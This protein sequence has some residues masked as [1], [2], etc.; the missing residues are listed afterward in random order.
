MIDSNYVMRIRLTLTEKILGTAPSD[1]EIY[2]NFIGSKAEN[3][4]TV[5]EEVEVLGVDEV[6]EKGMTIFPKRLKDG[7]PFIYDYQMKGFFKEA[8][9]MLRRADKDPFSGRKS[10]KY[11][12]SK[13]TNYKRV[14]DGLIEPKPREILI[15]TTKPIGTC[16]RPLRANTAQGERTALAIS[17]EIA[18]GS[19]MEFYVEIKHP[20]YKMAIREWLNYGEDHGLG[21]WRNSGCGRFLWEELDNDSGYPVYGNK[22]DELR[23][24]TD[25]LLETVRAKAKGKDKEEESA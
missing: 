10:N 6:V 16:Q 12:S 11:L 15:R 4:A 9:A 25:K 13:I 1:E 7:K 23:T 8:C 22:T 18:A 2:R 20:S 5:E 24:K 21:Q 14:I 17:E 3:A 19:E